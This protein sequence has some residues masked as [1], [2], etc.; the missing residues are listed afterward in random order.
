MV[1]I[2]P[3]SVENLIVLPVSIIVI[4]E[5]FFTPLLWK[6]STIIGVPFIATI[7]ILV[8]SL[9]FSRERGA[10]RQKKIQYLKSPINHEIFQFEIL[11]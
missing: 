8:F 5:K 11:W 9:K 3:L 10:S 6:K 2:S 4:V 7:E 1:M